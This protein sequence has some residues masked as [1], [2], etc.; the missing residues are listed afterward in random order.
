MATMF[1][2]TPHINDY[3]PSS[4]YCFS[5]WD[6]LIF[7]LFPSLSCFTFILLPGG[8]YFQLSYPKILIALHC[9]Q[10]NTGISKYHIGK[11]I[12]IEY[13]ILYL[14]FYRRVHKYCPCFPKYILYI[15]LHITTQIMYIYV[16]SSCMYNFYT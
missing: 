16:H 13:L 3:F 2:Y 15:Y 14:F 8:I 5:L 10:T 4:Y 9:N 11:H 1:T 6:V 7:H 12:I